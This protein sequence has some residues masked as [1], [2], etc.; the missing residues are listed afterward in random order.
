MQEELNKI[1]ES[2]EMIKR[3]EEY[4]TCYMSFDTFLKL[5]K[6]E[7]SLFKCVYGKWYISNTN[8]EI[9]FRND[10][11]KDVQMLLANT[12]CLYSEDLLDKEIEERSR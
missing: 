8:I 4:D 11:P 5:F 9:N 1:I 3:P 6:K 12:K 2:I 10:L 7:Y